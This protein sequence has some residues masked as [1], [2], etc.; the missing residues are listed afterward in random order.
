MAEVGTSGGNRAAGVGLIR[1]AQ[2]PARMS[3]HILLF[4]FLWVA[5]FAVTLKHPS[6]LRVIE[7]TQGGATSH[8]SIASEFDILAGK[9]N[10]M[11]E[12]RVRSLSRG[13]PTTFDWRLSRG[14]HL[15]PVSGFPH[16]DLLTWGKSR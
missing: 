12:L 14:Y 2:H 5:A 8:V 7:A 9:V 4:A 6:F 10:S 16:S 1:V 11:I 15:A 3:R 13:G